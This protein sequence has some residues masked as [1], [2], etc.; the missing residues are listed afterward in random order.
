M[1][2][3]QNIILIVSIVMILASFITFFIMVHTFISRDMAKTTILL[4]EEKTN[5]LGEITPAIEE[6]IYI[7]GNKITQSR[8]TYF[9]IGLFYYSMLCVAGIILYIIKDKKTLVILT[10]AA[11]ILTLLALNFVYQSIRLPIEISRDA[12]GYPLSF[13][14]PIIYFLLYLYGLKSEKKKK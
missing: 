10:T 14:I 13:G 6:S 2:K 12:L 7:T 11:I 4:V 9:F 1:T 8:N 3:K 5:G